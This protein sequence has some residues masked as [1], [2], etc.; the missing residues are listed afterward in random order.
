MIVCLSI[1]IRNMSI[2]ISGTHEHYLCSSEWWLQPAYVFKLISL[3][4][5]TQSELQVLYLS[6][7]EA[8]HHLPRLKQSDMKYN[9]ITC[10]VENLNIVS[11]SQGRIESLYFK[12]PSF[13]D[14][15]ALWDVTLQ[16]WSFQKAELGKNPFQVK[17]F[18]FPCFGDTGTILDV[19][20][21]GY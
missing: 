14:R 7:I 1:S 21:H 6:S 20:L 18:S 2:V 13:I 9:T 8:S 4:E 10:Q 16:Y 19:L 5:I 12:A 11:F 17:N 3:S 15:D